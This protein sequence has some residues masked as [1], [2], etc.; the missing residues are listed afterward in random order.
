MAKV[1]SKNK[2][3]TSP[4]DFFLHLLNMVT[5]YI[6]AVG[7]GNLL[8]VI[9]NYYFPDPLSY[10]GGSFETIRWA[11]SSI[12]I[13]FPVFIIASRYLNN[14][15]KKDPAKKNLRIKN[16]LEY[17][18]MFGTAVI[19]LVTF[20]TVVY[21]FIGGEVT[22]RFI[23]KTLTM[24]YIAG[25]ILGYY[26]YIVRD[27]SKSN[28]SHIV[29]TLFWIVTVTMI[30]A[31]A[32]GFITAGSPSKARDVKF[33]ETRINDLQNI[34]NEVAN[35]WQRKRAL[36]QNFDELGRESYFAIPKDPVNGT[37]YE[38]QVKDTMTF[39]LCATFALDKQRQPSN[40]YSAPM[41]GGPYQNIYNAEYKAGRSCFSYTIN[42]D[43][44][45]PIVKG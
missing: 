11:I 8:F 20:M 38:Y 40:E 1:T 10:S 42:P 17:F 6:A 21:Y 7:F 16:W 24:L 12:V 39:E 37:A 9:I 2:P 28:K 33:D 13:A 44:Y 25:T 4:K 29:K 31:I 14:E 26:F 36:P 43:Y 3:V 18:T 30:L 22:V 35:F 19:I 15:Y 5:L 34:Q 41:Y 32:G 23:L 45:P 27:N